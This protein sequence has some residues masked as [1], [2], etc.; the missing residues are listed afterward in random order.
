M[1]STDLD[2]PCGD[3]LPDAA[4]IQTALCYLMTR[5]TLRPYSG[6]IFTIMHHLQMLL[7]DPDVACLPERRKIHRKLLQHWKSIA[8]QQQA[9]GLDGVLFRPTTL[10]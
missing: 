6:L 1:K 8:L 10:N 4:L 9:T 2:T 5:Y 7:A 3:V